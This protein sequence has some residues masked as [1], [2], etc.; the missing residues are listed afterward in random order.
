MKTSKKLKLK[1]KINIIN[2]FSRVLPSSNLW[3]VETDQIINHQS[4]TVLRAYGYYL[5][6]HTKKMAAMM[7]SNNN[8]IPSMQQQ[9]QAVVYCSN[10]QEYYQAIESAGPH[11]LVV[12]DCYAEW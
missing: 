7:M 3:K 9:E 5:T 6:S 12:V 10:E 4:L 2:S 8:G 11:R 1:Q